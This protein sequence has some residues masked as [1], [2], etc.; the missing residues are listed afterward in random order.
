M[1]DSGMLVS[2]VGAALSE[3]GKIA[4]L[5][6]QRENGK[7]AYIDFLAAGAGPM[8]LNIEEALAKVFEMQRARLKGQDPRTFFAV[9]SK[10]V[11]A[12]KPA[13]AAGHP[14]LSLELE[15][16]MRLDFALPENSLPELIGWL[17]DWEKVRIQPESAKH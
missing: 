17:Q 16:G 12:L 3:D 8:L 10:R 1:V 4:Q 11:K 2:A 13:I 7:I 6:F 15:S 9:G 14:I 5:Q